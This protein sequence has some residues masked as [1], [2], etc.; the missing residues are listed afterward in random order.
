MHEKSREP[1]AFCQ[2]L[3]VAISK[4]TLD[5]AESFVAAF[6]LKVSTA[7]GEAVWGEEGWFGVETRVE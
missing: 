5:G 4:V 7:T 1:V 6:L 2:F 3:K